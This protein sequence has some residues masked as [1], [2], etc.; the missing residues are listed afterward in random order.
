MSA[1]LIS[2]KLGL[3]AKEL[4]LSPEALGDP[5]SRDLSR[6]IF[7]EFQYIGM[8]RKAELESAYI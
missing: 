2:L 6:L 3:R 8:L 4:S 1:H 7:T 5:V